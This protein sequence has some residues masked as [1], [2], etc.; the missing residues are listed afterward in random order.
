MHFAAQQLEAEAQGWGPEQ[1]AAMIGGGVPG[2]KPGALGAAGSKLKY[3]HGP[4]ESATGYVYHATNEERAGDIAKEGMKRYRPHIFTD[5]ETWPDGSKER[6]NYF[7][8]TA[9][10]TWQFAPEEG[11][12][13]LLRVKSDAHPFKRESTGDVYSIKDVP[14]SKIEALTEQGWHP[15]S[16]VFGGT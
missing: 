15:I 8:P 11:A 12:P 2:A 6:R 3:V 10:N 9:V 7:T 5:Q 16:N 1:A 14:A 4:E 13:V